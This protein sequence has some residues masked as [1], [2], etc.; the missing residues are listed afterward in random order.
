MA[1]CPA[2]DRDEE[3]AASLAELAYGLRIRAIAFEQP[4]GNVNERGNPAMHEKT[5]EQRCRGCAVDVVI[6]EDRDPFPALDRIGKSGSGHLH[7]TQDMRIRYQ[8]SHCRI[9]KACDLLLLHSAAG[10][11][12]SQQLRDALALRHTE[13]A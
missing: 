13:G 9:E 4:I 2:I 7:V 1:A 5:P 10:Q 8:R 3:R 6:P 11:D 12:P